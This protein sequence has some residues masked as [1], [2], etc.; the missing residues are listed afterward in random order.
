MLQ[1]GE[2]RLRFR[3][4]SKVLSPLAYLCGLE[5]RLLAEAGNV[6]LGEETAGG[7]RNERLLDEEN[8]R[9]EEWTRHSSIFA[10]FT[11]SKTMHRGGALIFLVNARTRA[12][13][14]DR[15]RVGRPRPACL[16]STGRACVGPPRQNFG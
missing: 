9:G 8:M 10:V 7:T 11:L 15:G 16:A 5:P 1:D 13:A 14:C 3:A 12:A 4:P 6:L 2:A